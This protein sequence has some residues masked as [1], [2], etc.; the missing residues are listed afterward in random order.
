MSGTR[1]IRVPAFLKEPLEAAQGRLEQFEEEAQR[2]FKDLMDK[3]RASRKDLEQIVA[4][5]SR[6]DFTLPE[7]KHRLERLRDQGVER[8]AGLRGKA[9]TWR[10][11]AMERLS[12]L[13]ARAVAFLGVA[14]RDEV[15]E[16]S[17][18]IDRLA[19]RIEKSARPRRRKASRPAAEV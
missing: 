8:A 17:R 4:R 13:Q 9:E 7:L 15:Q 3:G 5:L 11:E 1:T 12:D 18:E 19:R 6:Q 16:L 2:L 14:S 10:S